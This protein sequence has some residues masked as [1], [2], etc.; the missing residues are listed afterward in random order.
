MKK[1]I[2]DKERGGYINMGI[3]FNI[4]NNLVSTQKVNK[5]RYAGF[6]DI[7]ESNGN[8]AKTDNSDTYNVTGKITDNKNGILTLSLPDDHKGIIIPKDKMG[9]VSDGYHTFD[10][11]YHHRAILFAALCNAFPERSWKSKLHF[12]PDEKMYEGMFIVGIEC[13]YGLQATYHYDIDPYWDIFNCKVL[14]TA[15]HVFLAHNPDMALNRILNCD[16]HK[17]CKCSHLDHLR[18]QDGEPQELGF[19]KKCLSHLKK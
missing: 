19:F 18:E 2:E 4:D 1:D 13:E 3:V 10:E 5:D 8:T 17:P 12:D 9:N 7:N 14:L 16:F 11:L 15:P 6:H